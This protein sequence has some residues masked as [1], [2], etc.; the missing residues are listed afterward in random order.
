MAI[1]LKRDGRRGGFTLLELLVVTALLGILASLGH[2]SGRQWL[3]DWQVNR[4]Q[5]Q[6]YEDLKLA[7]SRA[8]QSGGTVLADGRLVVQ[9][10]FLVFDPEQAAY[11]LYRW[12]DDDGDG[13]P[14][15]EENR[16]L[17]QRQLPAG[18]SFRFAA[19]VDRRACSNQTVAPN[20][21]VTFGS[22]SYPPCLGRPCVK[23]DSQGFS[24]TG[25]GAV[26]LSD[27][28]RSLALSLTRPGLFTLCRWDGTR[29]Q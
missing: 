8:E 10:S 14:Q 16:R 4:A 22:P 24:V 7:Q 12:R 27:G 3:R 18:V 17:W 1:L 5:Q 11:G 28:R 6:L 25:P 19:A 26:Y 2:W 13:V 23:F 29:W 21:A 20:R 15:P 9:R